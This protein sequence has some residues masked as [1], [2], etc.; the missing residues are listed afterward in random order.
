MARLYVF[1]S[2]NVG[3]CDT[4]VCGA[5]YSVTV[6]ELLNHQPHH[7]STTRIPIVITCEDIPRRVLL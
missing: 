5:H 3:V 1:V 6:V 4:S 2:V 7:T